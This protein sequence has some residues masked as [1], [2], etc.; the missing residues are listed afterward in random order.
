MQTPTGGPK[1]SIPPKLLVELPANFTRNF[2]AKQIELQFD[3]FIK[4]NNFQK[5]FSISPDID[6]Q[7]DYKVKK[8]NLI[9]T[10]PDTLEEN[11]TYTINFGK[12]LVDFNEGNPI[13]NYNYVFAT[14]PELDSLSISGTVK[15]AYTKT[16]DPKQDLSVRVLLIPTR[17]DSI[18]GNKKAN[19]F[20]NVDSSGNF[21]LKNLREDTYRIYA[22]KEENN[23]R[24]YNNPDELIGFFA[25]SIVLKSDVKDINIEYSKGKPK[26][27]RVSERRIQKDGRIAIK[28]N[29]PLDSPSVRIIFPANLQS[30]AIYKYA[31]TNDSLHVLLPK[32]E[33]DSIKLE[34]SDKN[35]V[36]DT[37]LLRRGKNDKYDRELKPIL[38][39]SNKVDKINHITITSDFPIA[40]I[41]KEK[42]ILK[43]DSLSRRNFQ[44]QKDSIES[45]LYHIRFNWRPKRNYELILEEKAII[46]VFNDFNKELKTTFTLDETDN[47]GDIKFIINS[48]DS[49]V[50]YI[51]QLMDDKMEKVID[52]KYLTNA[53]Q[54]NY[55]KFPGGKYI[56]RVIK[57]LNNNRRWDGVDVYKKIQAEPI[58]YMDKPFTIRANWEQTE[59][60]TPKF[61]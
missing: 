53:N 60:I 13:V 41:D 14:G 24:I 5:E 16:F 20:T 40:N 1:D 51:V 36:L 22:L 48:L 45:N 10:L 34:I 58:W 23:D 15:N 55:S 37:T 44:L 32:L 21:I 8:K 56:L 30:E 47:F 7:P 26:E 42:L 18:F 43:E 57:D 3:E 50:N 49:N 25:D 52:S 11:T 38:N 29:Q 39:I 59:N 17:Q 4:L 27:F 19:I 31:L 6:K 61:E 9:I 35:K 54:L 28:F 12:G 33:F 2:K 46:S